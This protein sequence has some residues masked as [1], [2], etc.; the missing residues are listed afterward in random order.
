M[1]RS[2]LRIVSRTGTYIPLSPFILEILD[3]SEFRRS[4]PKKSTLK[5]LDLEY[6]I[7]APAAYVKTRIYQESLGDELVFLLG[8]YH[9]AISNQIA[10]PEMVLPILVALKRHLKKRT[11][12]SGKVQNGVK[13]LVDKLEATRVWVE[14]KRRNAS[15]APRDKGEL[16]KWTETVK[17]EDTPI[18]G[19]MRLQKKVREQKRREVERALREEKVVDD[20]EED[21][22]SDDDE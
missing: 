2:L 1:L 12:G 8:D 7:R 21:D 3:S 4:N 15:F 18:G 9:A 6:V 20:D 17:I 13:T 5:P 19:W 16:I 14:N 11:A 22:E 10:F